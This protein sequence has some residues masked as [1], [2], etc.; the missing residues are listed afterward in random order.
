MNKNMA[1]ALLLGGGFLVALAFMWGKG[2]ETHEPAPVEGGSSTQSSPSPAP[3]LPVGHKPVPIPIPGPRP[4]PSPKDTVADLFGDPPHEEES[5]F[6]NPRGVGGTELAKN[7]ES[8]VPWLGK[9][10]K[11]DD[12]PVVAA[13]ETYTVETTM[14]LVRISEDA[15]GDGERWR[16]I[17]ELN[18]DAIRDADRVARGTVLRIPADGR[19]SSLLDRIG[20]HRRSGHKKMTD[21]ID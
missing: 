21:L 6:I 17:L 4:V 18:S 3:A 16:E 14:S 5:R 2:D 1:I 15:L 9:E 11:K 8:V 10:K 20:S 13:Y 19:R 7:Q 12:G